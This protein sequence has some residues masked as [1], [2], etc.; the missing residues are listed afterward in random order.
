M[1]QKKNITPFVFSLI[2]PQDIHFDYD[3]ILG[4]WMSGIYANIP[5]LK[6]PVGLNFWL[7][8]LWLFSIHNI[9]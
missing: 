6:A 1:S 7:I 4:S 5:Y 3:A 8:I 2:K 9:T